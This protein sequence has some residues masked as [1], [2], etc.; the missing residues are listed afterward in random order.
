MCLCVLVHRQLPSHSL[1]MAA[2]RE[3]Q[4][5]RPSLAPD[6]LPADPPVFAGQDQRAGGTWQGL[7][8]QGLV[9]ALTNRRGADLDP[10]HRS[11]GLLCLDALG[12][13]SAH[14]AA[15]WLLDHL[16]TVPYNPCNLLCADA[17]HA[18][19][20]HYDGRQARGQELSPGLHLLAD[21]EIDDGEHPRV[22]RARALLKD[23]PP[24]WPELRTLLAR[25]MADHADDPPEGRI[26][27]HGAR[28]GT[29]SSSLIALRGPGLEG[30]QFH[31]APGPPCAHQYQ[32]LSPRLCL[33]VER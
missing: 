15:A 13:P 8:A 24:R 10:G 30:A 9:V 4:Y 1:V 5:H 32:D 11:R 6:W 22:Q 25:L 12:H 31:F 21:T 16:R 14:Q 28:A 2:N 7:N 17:H 29:V 20:V 23:P 19:A 33:S 18:L 26:C 3:E 27:R